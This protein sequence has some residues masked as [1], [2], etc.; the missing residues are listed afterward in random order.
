MQRQKHHEVQ[1]AV[2]VNLGDIAHVLNAGHIQFEAQGSQQGD[3]AS[4]QPLSTDRISPAFASAMLVPAARSTV[5][6]AISCLRI[7]SC[8]L[9]LAPN[10]RQAP[11]S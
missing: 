9:T 1:V 11:A 10:K 7:C 6:S 3:G 2:T 4:P 5:L 8:L